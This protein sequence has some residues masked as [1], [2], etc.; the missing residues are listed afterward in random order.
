MLLAGHVADHLGKWLELAAGLVL[1]GLGTWT[2]YSHLA[3]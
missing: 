2:L 3:A 1:I